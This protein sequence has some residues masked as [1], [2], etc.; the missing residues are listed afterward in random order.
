MLL[1]G[2]VY[3]APDGTRGFDA[4][5]TITPSVAAAFHSH[6]YRFCV[7][8]VRR[9]QPHAADLTAQEAGNLLDAGLGLMIVQHVESETSW[10]PTSDKGAAYG[11]TAAAE[12]EKI[13]AP[14]GVTVWCDLEGVAV[15]TPAEQIVEY[16]NQWHSA[17]AAAG[18]VP[19]LYVG[20]HAGLNQT[21]LYRSL[22]FGHYWGAYNLN[23][24]E[25]PAVRGLQMKQAAR[26]PLDAVPGASFEFQVDKIRGDALGGRPTL[27]G[28]DGWLDDV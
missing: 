25:A 4:N 22:R 28:P 26:K 6:G 23:A 9:E 24:D 7:R 3:S 21:Q 2:H 12:A 14:S 17:V 1:H 5:L 15:Q 20:Y 10:T 11:A 16:C 13:G 8:Y 18:Y 27:L 19:G